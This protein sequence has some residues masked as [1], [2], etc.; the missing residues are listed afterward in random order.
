MDYSVV[1]AF[2]LLAMGLALIVAELFLP[3]GGVISILCA[4]CLGASIY[5]AYD[6]WW[7]DSPPAFWWFVGSI[8][9]LIPMTV[10]GALFLLSRTRLGSRV[11]LDAPKLEEVTPY[12]HEAEQRKQLIGKVGKTLTLMAPGGLVV[13]DGQRLHAETEGQMLDPQ[14]PVKII[15]VRGNRVVVRSHEPVA[16]KPPAAKTNERAAASEEAAGGRA[17]L[18]PAPE[19]DLA[20]AGDDH[21]PLDFEIPEG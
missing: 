8:V 16:E 6:A 19:I 20:E 15:A 9:G 4:V 12:S 21:V 18:E 3:S 5:C 13:V 10:G 1:F 2:V 11:F 7:E 14:Q 17:P